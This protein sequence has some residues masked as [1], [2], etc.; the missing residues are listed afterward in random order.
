MDKQPLIPGVQVVE[1]NWGINDP[2]ADDHAHPGMF[3]EPE[4]PM[5]VFLPAIWPSDRR[6]WTPVGSYQTMTYCYYPAAD[7][8]DTHKRTRTQEEQTEID[9]DIDALLAEVGITPRPR[10]RVHYLE[11][12]TGIFD[13]KE[14]LE[15]ITARAHEEG[16]EPRCHKAFVLVAIQVIEEC[17]RSTEMG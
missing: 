10:G 2:P 11:M 16:V 12:P 9:N 1:H 4:A 13:L 14:I 6:I 8:S 3:K 17:F 5:W 15:S 7:R